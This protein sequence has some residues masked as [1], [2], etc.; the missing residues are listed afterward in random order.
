MENVIVSTEKERNKQKAVLH[1]SD[2]QRLTPVVSFPI[3]LIDKY[4][5]GSYRAER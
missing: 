2:K 1:I 4:H 5:I 3:A